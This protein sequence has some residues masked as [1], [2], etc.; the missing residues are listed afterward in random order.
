MHSGMV[1]GVLRPRK[2][3]ET[4]G[5]VG[6][7]PGTSYTVR[8][9]GDGRVSLHT[10]A[11]IDGA[12]SARAAPGRASF[13]AASLGTKGREPKQLEAVKHRLSFAALASEIAER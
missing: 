3:P 2:R 5:N 13:I 9:L 6:E 7:H 11:R 1:R 10:N 12:C 4:S 8:S